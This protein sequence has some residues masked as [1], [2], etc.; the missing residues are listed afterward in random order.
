M[1][2]YK[3]VERGTEHQIDWSEV[4]KSISDVLNEK[5]K[6]DKKQ[7]D[8]GIKDWTTALDVVT[9]E[10]LG[11]NARVNN[12][13]GELSQMLT[14]NLLELNKAFVNGDASL[15]DFNTGMATAKQS[16]TD[17]YDLI[18]NINTAKTEVDKGIEDGKYQRLMAEE[19][20]YLTQSLNYKTHMPYVDPLTQEIYIGK[21]KKNED[22]TYS[23]SIEPGAQSVRTLLGATAYTY[24]S[25]Q[26][27]EVTQKYS[28]PLATMKQS[29]LNASGGV[30]T[31]ESI[32]AFKGGE[33]WRTFEDNF[34]DAQM[35][36]FDVSA[37]LTGQLLEKNYR[38]T[39]DEE[40]FKKDKTGE[41]FLKR[42][43]VDNG[44]L[45]LEFKDSQ[46]EEVRDFW[47]NLLWSQVNDQ[48]TM[49]RGSGADRK[50][51]Q[52]T[53]GYFEDLNNIQSASADR[54]NAI[55]SNRVLDVNQ[56]RQAEAKKNN[57][58]PVL[59]TD[60][61]RTP[62]AFIIKQKKGSR[63]LSPVTISR[64]DKDNKW[65]PANVV[66]QELMEYI[67]PYKGSF[68]EGEQV[69]LQNNT[70]SP[71]GGDDFQGGQESSYSSPNVTGRPVSTSTPIDMS[72]KTYA[73]RYDQLSKDDKREPIKVNSLMQEDLR[74]AYR[75][76][77]F[78][79]PTKQDVTFNPTI[80]STDDKSRKAE[81]I[82]TVPNMV[83][84]GE[85]IKFDPQGTKKV[86]RYKDY[87]DNPTRLLEE[88]FGELNKF[89][90]LNNQTIV[91]EDS[92]TDPKD[93]LDINK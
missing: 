50:L 65:L 4:G 46:K 37:I 88:I 17:T 38:G 54:A 67:T 35:G 62:D 15:K 36:Q 64:K 43:N 55:L 3:Y 76:L 91:G 22:G 8:Q 23:N 49:T 16:T 13:S 83:I 21:R 59:I 72:G 69:F 39:F 73:S 47:K 78:D 58:T 86:Y 25:V 44:E 14:T 6:A 60:I 75:N 41:L 56:F 81:F 27:L 71:I 40:E 5:A 29:W 31:Q 11:P 10:P 20:D 30:T 66:G 42:R 85:G 51:N 12:F 18:K 93:P 82:L 74:R 80:T 33:E 26:P 32:K 61:E 63:M 19:W 45:E 52:A 77:S 87:S 9:K 2:Y 84:T 79:T 92:T 7:V 90:D 53:Q 89:I 68:A 48:T 28:K 34:V 1:T 70:W 57:A 24:N